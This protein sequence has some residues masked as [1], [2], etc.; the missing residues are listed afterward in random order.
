MRVN[1]LRKV[2]VKNN[3]KIRALQ[4]IIYSKMLQVMFRMDSVKDPQMMLVVLPEGLGEEPRILPQMPGKELKI[5]ED[6]LKLLLRL[7][8]E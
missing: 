2:Q 6:K 1:W 8:Q 4:N 7:L 3:R 5:L